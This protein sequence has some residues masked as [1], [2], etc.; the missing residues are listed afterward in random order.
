MSTLTKIF[1]VVFVVLSIFAS[2]VFIQY[3][4][5]T[6]NYRAWGTGLQQQL[7]LT[8]NQLR[9]IQSQLD[10]QQALYQDLQDRRTQ[11]QS[12]LQ[13]RVDELQTALNETKAQT[14]ALQVEKTT[15]GAT[16]AGL[17]ATHD[18]NVEML[19]LTQQQLTQ[20]RQDLQGINTQLTQQ[21]QMLAD[22][23]LELEQASRLLRLRQEQLTA[24]SE[25]VRELEARGGTAASDRP[26]QPASRIEGTLTAVDPN[27]NLAQIN[28]GSADGVTKGT[29]FILYRGG[30][31]VGHLDVQEVHATQAAG[32]LTEVVKTP[33]AG[34]KATT[35]LTLQ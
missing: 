34:D 27:N 12:A 4:A 11:E 10:R 33:M 14:A 31:F 5:S 8:Q 13:T 3:A 29:R 28:V 17:Q 9:A 32:I 7:G 35:R 22:T 2:L 25:R 24:A 6:A 16:L 26:A 15:Q 23:R 18:K 21:E 19:Q 30:E 1:I 20:A